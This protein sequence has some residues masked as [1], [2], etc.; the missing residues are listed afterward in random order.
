[1]TQ[2]LKYILRTEKPIENLIELRKKGIHAKLFPDPKNPSKMVIALDE[3]TE[4]ESKIGNIEKLGGNIIDE[5]YS[6]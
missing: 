2:N 4:N 6:H 1:M 5:Y 3:I